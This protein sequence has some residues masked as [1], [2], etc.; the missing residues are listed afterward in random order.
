MANSGLQVDGRVPSPSSTVARAR[1]ASQTPV[2]LSPAGTTRA[3]GPAAAR[4]GHTGRRDRIVDGELG[5]FLR[6][7]RARLTP[8]AAGLPSYGARR[9]PGLRREELAQLAGVSA[10]YYTRLEQ[11]QSSNASQAVIDA[12]ARALDLD[13]D[14]RAH[15]HDLARPAPREAA[16]TAAARPRP[17][18][19]RRA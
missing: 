11:G 4:S 15:L 2:R 13:D 17:A 3:P 16:P 9:V 14:E 6:S 1:T 12:L 7:R 8:E 18:R 5:A 10:T 19:H